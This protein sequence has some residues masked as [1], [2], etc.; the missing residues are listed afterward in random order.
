MEL[1][2]RIAGR[3]AHDYLKLAERAGFEPAKRG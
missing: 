2:S 1:E 3:D